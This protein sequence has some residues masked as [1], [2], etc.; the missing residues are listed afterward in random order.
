VKAPRDDDDRLW[1]A[2][3]DPSRRRP[4]D[5]L[6]ARGEATPTTLAGD[7]PFS[8][9][10]VSKHLTTLEQAG[11]VQRSQRGRET[12]YAVRPE[13]VIAAAEALVR[14]AAEWDRR[15]NAIKAIAEAVHQGEDHV[16]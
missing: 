14:A 11:L 12:W 5:L 16:E 6:L 10:A 7:L 1:S 9:Q 2:V 8:R 13:Q 4:L 15:L 3:A